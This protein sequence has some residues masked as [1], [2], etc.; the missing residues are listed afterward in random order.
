MCLLALYLLLSFTR[1]TAELRLGYGDPAFVQ[2]LRISL[3]IAV[4]SAMFLS[5]QYFL[6]FWLVGGLAGA[7]W[8]DGQRRAEER[9]TPAPGAG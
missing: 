3:T 8:V 2:A 9:A 5:E 1:L 7:I 6:P 4:V